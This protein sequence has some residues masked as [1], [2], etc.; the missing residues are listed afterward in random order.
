[1]FRAMSDV[2]LQAALD[3]MTLKK[4]DSGQA[5]YEKDETGDSMVVVLDGILRVEIDDPSGKPRAIATIQI[6]ESVGEMSV[7]D[8]APRSASVVAASDVVLLELSRDDLEDL[9]RHT[10]SVSSQIVS[11]I[12]VDLTKRLRK[13]NE[14]IEREL[15]PNVDLQGNMKNKTALNDTKGEEAKGGFFNRLLKGI[16]R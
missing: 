7:I 8:P 6:G 1:M 2:E 13:V 11:S 9:R 3:R 4:L 16:G 15:D 5:L 10:P 12:I 14:R